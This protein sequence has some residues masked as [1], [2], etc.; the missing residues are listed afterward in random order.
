MS[1][2]EKVYNLK[3]LLF[4]R[5]NG[6]FCAF[7]KFLP[8][9]GWKGRGAREPKAPWNPLYKC[10]Q[11]ASNFDPYFCRFGRV[12]WCFHIEFMVW[13]KPSII[14]MTWIFRKKNYENFLWRVKKY[15]SCSSFDCYYFGSDAERNF[16]HVHDVQLGHHHSYDRGI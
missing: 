3:K 7:T 5:I 4:I 16:I 8:N 6:L 11:Y 9:R 13:K 1:S 12:Y 15:V 14:K 10:G 2:F